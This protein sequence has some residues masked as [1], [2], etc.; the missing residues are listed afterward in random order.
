MKRIFVV[1]HCKAEEQAPSAELT[2]QGEKQAIELADFF[3]DRNI[4]YIVSSPYERAHATIKPLAQHRQLEI[5][6]DDRL[7]ERILTAKD[8]PD[9]YDMLRRTFDDLDL[10]YEGGESSHEATQRILHVLND[11][12]QSNHT[13]AVI[14]S[15][16]NLISLLLH[17]FDPQ[18][19]FKEWERMTNPDV[20]ELLFEE[21][22]S[23]QRPLLQRIWVN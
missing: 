10:H 12:L 14:V 4:D 7:T 17:Y 20:F 15:H 16:G 8:H 13:N 23:E 18:M 2:E 3:T 22:S 6:L 1:R 19:G 11:I 21:K 9:W 5:Q